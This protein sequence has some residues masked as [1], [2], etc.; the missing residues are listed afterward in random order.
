MQREPVTVMADVP[1]D[2]ER[3]AFAVLQEIKNL[4]GE[5]SHKKVA[6]IARALLSERERR[7]AQGV[8]WQ[9]IET[10]H[11]ADKFTQAQ[12]IFLAHDEKRWVR[13]GRYYPEMKRWYYSGTNERSQWAQ[14]EGDAPT[15]W[16]F[17]PAAP[18]LST[19]AGGGE[20]G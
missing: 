19:S 2:I 7:T 9:P 8:T 17:L 12:H 18:S 10:Y 5:P 15:H 11:A 14:V 1:K 20:R 4:Q 6:V 3:E 13:M 16:M